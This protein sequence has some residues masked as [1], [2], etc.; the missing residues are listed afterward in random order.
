MVGLWGVVGLLSL[1]D[2][3]LVAEAVAFFCGSCS[4]ENVGKGSASLLSYL[5]IQS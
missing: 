4:I 2:M 3:W 5:R 1:Y